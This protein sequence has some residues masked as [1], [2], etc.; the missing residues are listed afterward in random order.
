MPKKLDE[1]RAKRS[2]ET[3][4]E[5]FGGGAERPQLFVVQKHAARRLHYD[6]RLELGGTLKSWAVPKGPSF[7]P[8]EK[9]LAVQVED[10]PVEYADFEGVIPKGNYGAGEVIVWDRGRWV[11]LEDPV[12]GLE[13]GK[14]LFELF[15][16]KLRGVWT[17]VRT[18]GT[19]RAAGPSRDW[20]LIKHADGWSGPG[21][22]L[23]QASVLSGR[24]VEQLREG[25]PPLGEALAAQV[26]RAGAPALRP[27]ASIEPML[28]ETGERPFSRPGW[29]FELKLD[30]FRALAVREGETVKLVYRRGLD[31]SAT[32]PEVVQAL[33]ALPFPSFVLDGELTVLDAQGKPSFQ[34][35]Q[36]RAQLSRRTDIERMAI[37]LPTTYFAFDLLAFGGRDLRPLPL[38]E[39]KRLLKQLLPAAGPLRYV[40]HV[41]E[42]GAELYAEV[43]ARGLEGVV[44][45]RADAPY[46]AGR[47]R[48]WIKW[49]TERTGDFVVVGFTEPK[50]SRLGLGSLHVAEYEGDELT[51]RG[52]V[53]SGLSDAVLQKTRSELDALG[54]AKP[55]CRHSELAVGKVRWV[56][57]KLVCEVRYKELTSE[58]LLRQSTL[59][60]F[61]EDKAPQDCR[62]R[63][64]VPPPAPADPPEPTPKVVHFTNLDKVFWPKEGYTKGD[65]I[66]YYREIAPWLLPYLRDRPL[67]LTRFPDGI[68]G[69]SFYQKDAPGFAPGWIR[70]ERIWS[71]QAQRE[72]DYFVC[73][74]VETLVYLANLG[75]IPIHVWASRIGS[76]ERPDWSIVDL[77]PK[78]APFTDVV[79]LARA[80]HDLCEEISLPCFLKTSGATGLHVLLPLGGQCSYA[81]SRTLAEIIAR[82]IEGR[83][84]DISTTARALAER[85]GKVYLDYLQNGHGQTIAAPFSARPVAAA[86]VS[87]PLR[88]REATARL[89]PKQFTLRNAPARMRKLKEDPMAP[90][91]S[92]RPDLGRVLRA[93]HARIA[94]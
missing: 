49:R 62:A 54:V 36:K 1:Y 19:A 79:K 25:A 74:D 64:P 21:R 31:A 34:G 43:T 32:Y 27:R 94:R 11:P 63:P 58:G 30:G 24:T 6:F 90:V 7:D 47:S 67:V 44:A 4:P 48:D 60:R 89:D 80:V 53:G 8:A 50:G 26:E 66:D 83:H 81:E 46:R 57:P 12:R 15:G 68:E 92:L 40:D 14:L 88:W 69:K 85:N 51:Y 2:A 20:L 76:E 29:I 38:L 9:R 70:T 23:G 18:K 75:T 61:R 59:L 78:G 13:K 35:L 39:R 82:T 65:L 3:T 42:K 87:M 84:G 16:Y 5:P 73:N 45:K 72:I 56:Q 91:L 86:S 37:E 22:T 55:A 52:G 77:D 71:E 41:E 10:H 28:A 17:L 93:L 33:R